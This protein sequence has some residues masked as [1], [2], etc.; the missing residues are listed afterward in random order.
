[1]EFLCEKT[2]FP[3][4][5]IITH[6]CF[7][8]ERGFFLESYREDALAKFEVPHFVQD[9]HSRSSRGVLRGLHYQIEPKS[10][11]KLVRC[12]QGEIF[13]AVVDIRVGSI[14]YG[15]W[16]GL[17]LSQENH[18]MLYVPPGFAHGFVTISEHAE[19]F[20][21]MTDYYSKEHDKGIRWNDPAIGIAW[22]ENIKPLLS[23]KDMDAPILQDAENNLTF[24]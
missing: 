1:M 5:L 15:K 21:K 10:A 22:P 19:I 2:E 14:T 3:G 24:G 16:F 12:M 7:E 4:L 11:G 18:K 6:E 8:D 20:Y 23:A 9:N 17:T 13:D